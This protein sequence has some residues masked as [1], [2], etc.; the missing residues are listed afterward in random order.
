MKMEARIEVAQDIREFYTLKRV[1]LI[2][3]GAWCWRS[4]TDWAREESTG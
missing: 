1:G 2:R 4:E 3:V